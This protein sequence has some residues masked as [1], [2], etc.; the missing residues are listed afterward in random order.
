MNSER[1]FNEFGRRPTSDGKRKSA[2]KVGRERPTSEAGI[3]SHIEV[4]KRLDVLYSPAPRWD[5][6]RRCW[7]CA[8]CG[9]LTGTVT[10]IENHARRLHPETVIASPSSPPPTH[11]GGE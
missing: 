7:V 10:M 4:E 8:C 11:R 9:Y 5:Y 2:A 3:K 6:E 1:A